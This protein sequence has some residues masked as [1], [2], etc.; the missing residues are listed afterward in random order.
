MGGRGLG[1]LSPPKLNLALKKWWHYK[2]NPFREGMNPK[3][4]RREILVTVS[5]NCHFSWTLEAQNRWEG[6]KYL[7][8][9]V[10]SK[11]G[12]LKK[13]SAPKLSSPPKKKC[14]CRN[15]NGRLVGNLPLPKIKMS[16]WALS[17]KNNWWDSKIDAF[18]RAQNYG[19]EQNIGREQWFW[20]IGV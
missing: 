16:K 18:C 4:M 2:I 6:A 9:T 13:I 12:D 19:I 8:G 11:D 10:V 17:L 5:Q 15:A 14:L 3:S 20:G 1:W 7:A